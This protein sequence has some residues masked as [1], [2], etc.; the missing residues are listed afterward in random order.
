MQPGPPNDLLDA[1]NNPQFYYGTSYFSQVSRPYSR[2][3]LIL[4]RL[5]LSEPEQWAARRLHP[6]GHHQ[7]RQ[8]RDDLPWTIRH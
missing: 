3:N 6:P 8:R 2:R 1:D 7:R 4:Q 5:I